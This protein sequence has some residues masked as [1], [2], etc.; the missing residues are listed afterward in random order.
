MLADILSDEGFAVTTAH[1]GK[2]GLE[3]FGAARFDLVITDLMMPVMSGEQLVAAIR[4][5][6]ESVPILVLSA[7]Y[8]SEVATRLGVAFC[9]KPFDLDSLLALIRDLVER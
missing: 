3:K 8:G 1:N 7:G 4:E 2:V 5:R 9:A 6:D